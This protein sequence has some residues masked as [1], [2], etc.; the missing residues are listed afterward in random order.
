MAAGK[1]QG[2]SLDGWN[3]AKY[4]NCLSILEK[5]PSAAFRKYNGV[6]PCPVSFH[7]VNCSYFLGLWGSILCESSTIT[8]ILMALA[9]KSSSVNYSESGFWKLTFTTTHIICKICFAIPGP[10]CRHLGRQV[11]RQPQSVWCAQCFDKCVLRWPHND[12]RVGNSSLV[13]RWKPGENVSPVKL[14]FKFTN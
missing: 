3:R 8:T 7:F 6:W 14:W 4:A 10:Q 12:S 9:I 5:G 1:C 13:N 2:K 11:T